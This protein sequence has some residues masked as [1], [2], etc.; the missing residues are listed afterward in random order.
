MT[1]ASPDPK[2]R[3]SF[4]PLLLV[5]MVL[6]GLCLLVTFVPL[7]DCVSCDGSGQRGNLKVTIRGQ[8]ESPE[9]MKVFEDALLC[10]KCKGKGKVPL[11]NIWSREAEETL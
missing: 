11:L 8:D 9:I 7:T 6:V 10:P 1:E 5:G 3:S 2:P 4:I